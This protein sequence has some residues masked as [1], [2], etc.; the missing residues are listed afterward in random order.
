MSA[1]SPTVLS[2]LGVPASAPPSARTVQCSEDGQVIVTT[3]PAIYILT[4]NFGLKLDDANAVK[5]APG[6][7]L[8]N[9]VPINLRYFRTHIELSQISRTWGFQPGAPWNSVVFGSLDLA[10]RACVP[11]PSGLS[12]SGGCMLAT[13]TTNLE[14]GLWAPMKS[15]VQGPWEHKQDI[16]SL[17]IEHYIGA[18]DS[19]STQILEAQ[20]ECIAWSSLPRRGGLSLLALG[21]RAGSVVLLRYD[22]LSLNMAHAHDVNV[23]SDRVVSLAWS[24]WQSGGDGVY[25]ALL[26]CG[27]PCGL[28][29]LVRVV[30]QINDDDNQPHL[31]CEIIDSD[32]E[33][34]PANADDTGITALEWIRARNDAPILVYC[35]PGF[36]SLYSH[37]EIVA[38]RSTPSGE[39]PNWSGTRVLP[40]QNQHVS[41]GSSSWSP[42]SGVIYVAE[43]D[44]LIVTLFDGSMHTI[45]E[46]STSP[47]LQASPD[48]ATLSTNSLTICARKIFVKHAP[49]V[50][51][52][53]VTLQ[54]VNRT[55]GITEFATNGLL[56]SLVEPG[57]PNFFDYQSD[58]HQRSEIIISRMWEP[59][60]PV[61]AIVEMVGR[62]L[63]DP[64]ADMHVPPAN[65]LRSV[66]VHLKMPDTSAK[67]QGR[68]L[69]LLDA[70]TLPA[71]AI[72]PAAKASAEGDF[73]AHL[74]RTLHRS[75]W[76]DMRLRVLILQF[77]I[78]D[79]C[80]IGQHDDDILVQRWKRKL[81]SIETNIARARL[82]ILVE[83]LHAVVQDLSAPEH[84]AFLSRLLQQAT[85]LECPADVRESAS[86][87]AQRCGLATA[88][89][90]D[91]AVLQVDVCPACNAPL[92]ADNRGP[93]ARCV[94]GHLW[95]RCSVTSFI[96]ATPHVRTC[97]G[98]NRKALLAP[99]QL[100]DANT[101]STASKWFPQ[102]W[103]VGAILEAT[104][105]C[106]FCGNCFVV[107]I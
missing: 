27:L 98:C 107:L 96:L 43:H 88:S 95:A 29:S 19:P 74:H 28:I 87:L 50:F 92:E 10:W 25:Q 7:H 16:T 71:Y 62:I 15:W 66:F 78:A 32:L 57:R 42:A 90:A 69:A 85:T 48:P 34:V 58:A 52:R 76:K 18:E 37:P 70:T 53:Q 17:L 102:T 67:L 8:P 60:R 93:I 36:V 72:P 31:T 81:Q 4:P 12:P 41:A 49:H 75:V 80:I 61:D 6:S 40:L 73:A 26:A 100:H 91:A 47:T 21:N 39:G 103:V 54:D 77:A 64:E 82:A 46:V 3:K 97:A 51:Q 86:L 14:V 106:P 65:L 11:S 33:H 89:D 63:S 1:F 79:A 35:K 104:D 20:V 105:R 5:G 24:S 30:Q 22:G 94:R 59:V 84:A 13:L 45:H 2:T 101:P 99:T 56:L 68:L 23:T 9:T 83:N 55:T 44:V 38:G